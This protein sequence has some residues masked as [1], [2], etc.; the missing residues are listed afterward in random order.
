MSTSRSQ[1]LLSFHVTA[2]SWLS[3]WIRR[4]PGEHDFRQD[5]IRLHRSTNLTKGVEALS[6]LS[7][8]PLTYPDRQTGRGFFMFLYGLHMCARTYQ[9]H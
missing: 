9:R 6:G 7:F 4:D 8:G 2:K 5:Q 1:D 3:T